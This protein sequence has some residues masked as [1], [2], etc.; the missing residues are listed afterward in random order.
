[1][2]RHAIYPLKPDISSVS[3]TDIIKELTSCMYEKDLQLFDYGIIAKAILVDEV[4]EYGPTTESTFYMVKTMSCFV[5]IVVRTRCLQKEKLVIMQVS[6]DTI[7][8]ILRAIFVA[9]LNGCKSYFPWN[10]MKSVDRNSYSFQK[11]PNNCMVECCFR[12]RQI[13]G[14]AENI[15]IYKTRII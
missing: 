9:I 11:R 3:T 7:S 8:V 13:T 15:L 10:E 6:Y 14:V 12:S 2:P 5:D 4:V 1:M